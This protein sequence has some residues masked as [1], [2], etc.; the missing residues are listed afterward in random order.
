MKIQLGLM[1]V[2]LAV[3]GCGD[4]DGGTGGSTGSGGSGAS[5]TG[6]VGASSTGGAGAASS[7]GTGTTGGSG[8][9]PQCPKCEIGLDCCDGKCVNFKND[10]N[11]CGICGEQCTQTNPFC[12]DG[13]CSD[14]PCN[15]GVCTDPQF[16]CGTECCDDNMLCCV[17]QLGPV[18][19]PSCTKPTKEGS[20]P[21]GNPGSVCA[22]PDTPVATPSGER[23]IAELQV[24]DL[25]YSVHRGE[26]S[27]VPI[28]R[29]HRTAVTNHHVV[30][31]RLDNGAI[32]MI[33]PG[34]PTADGETFAALEPGD[35]L[36]GPAVEQVELVPYPHAYTHDILPAS[37]SAAYF[38][39]GALIGSTLTTEARPV[40]GACIEVLPGR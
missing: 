11:N 18:G 16:C 13:N 19:P 36:Y 37:D 39:A 4:D 38:T 7:G 24:G 34:H 14:P 31:L 9:A 17:V 3:A 23:E 6:G 2:V 27:V 30:R 12:D 32:L 8:G 33:S 5:S 29:V 35:V 26:L 28:E 21:P 40:A 15:G 10:I 22:A 25:V 1:A 20:C